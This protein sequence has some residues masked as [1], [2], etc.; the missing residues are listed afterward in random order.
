MII[1][2]IVE[3]RSGSTNLA[4]CFFNDDNFTVIYL[5]SDPL[6]KWY[7]ND[8]P[9]N[10]RYVTKHLMVKEDFYIEK[11]FKQLIDISDKTIF[12]YRENSEEQI[13]S[14]VN[15]KVT[16][17][18]DGA[19][20]YDEN[21][22]INQQQEI[23]YFKNLKSEFTK[24]VERTSNS[25]KISYEELYN[26]NGFD[27]IREFLGYDVTNNIIFPMGKRYRVNVNKSKSFI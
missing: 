6:S 17:N 19:W 26:N 23:E 24:L 11:D 13:R 12:L 4:N 1:S 15:A 10:Y 25:L 7:I 21:I 20:K 3:P 18:W 27:K 5:P 9:V 14:W 2:L 22:M 8:M 16:N